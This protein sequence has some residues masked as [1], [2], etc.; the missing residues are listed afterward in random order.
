MVFT[1]RRKKVLRFSEKMARPEYSMCSQRPPSSTNPERKLA[2]ALARAV[3]LR[4][5]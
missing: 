4:P 1:L 2:L 3:F 5:V